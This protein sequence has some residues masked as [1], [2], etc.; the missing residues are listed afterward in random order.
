MK[1]M[2][3]NRRLAKA[4]TD[5]GWGEIWL[6]SET[7]RRALKMEPNQPDHHNLMARYLTSRRLFA[8]AET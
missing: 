5:A 8:W 3:K 4:I 7:A 1:N 6:D 2:V